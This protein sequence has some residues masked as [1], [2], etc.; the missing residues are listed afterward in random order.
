VRKRLCETAICGF[1][2]ISQSSLEKLI[3]YLDRSKLKITLSEF[4]NLDEDFDLLTRKE[5]FPY[6]YIDSVDKLNETSLSPR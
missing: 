4:P 1:V 3:S 5:V 6:E 2:Q